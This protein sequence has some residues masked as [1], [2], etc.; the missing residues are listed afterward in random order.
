[1]RKYLFQLIGVA[2]CLI[3]AEGQTLAKSLSANEI[4]HRSNQISY[5]AGQDGRAQADMII[6]DDKGR[7]R[8]RQ[9]IVL[10]RDIADTDELEN[11]AYLSEQKLYVYFTHPTDVNKMGFLV[12]KNV[13]S[14]DER[15]LYVPSLDLV[16]R[17]AASDK[18]TSFVG[19]DFFYEDISGRN[20][21]DDHHELI[22]ITNNYYVIRNT[23]NNPAAVEFKYYKMYIHKETFIPVQVEYYDQK[24]ELY[25]RG[26]TLKV[27]TIQGYPTITEA[28]MENLRTGSSTL[29]KYTNVQYDIEL[30]DE[31]FS[32]RY[33]R[34]PPQQF[35]Y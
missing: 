9:M 24:D 22:E 1:M 30:T 17:I 3:L 26:K 32:E 12:W 25:R 13:A 34:N 7:K 21:N 19:S 11:N 35:L 14:N 33:L 28:S 29:M 23:P 16:R 10:R 18:R 31:V 4:V 8:H 15:W 2:A 5:Y 6:T 20:I 27:D